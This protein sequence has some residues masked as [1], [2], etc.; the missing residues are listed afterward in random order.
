[1]RS[2]FASEGPIGVMAAMPEEVAAIDRALTD[3]RVE[4][5]G[6]RDYH[7]GRLFGR[8]VVAVTARI[9]K[10]AAASTATHLICEFGVGAI[11]LVGVAGGV[12]PGVHV[13]DVVVGAE[14]MQHDL[15]AS[16]LFPRFEAP[17]L[18]VA[19]FA[20]APEDI[21][22][23]EK[24]AG[25]FLA[26]DL[27]VALGADRLGALGVGAPRV[28]TG[29]I[30]TG[31]RFIASTPDADAVRAAAPEALA[32]EMEGAAVAQVCHEHGAGCLVI[33]AISDRA[34]EHATAAFTRALPEIAPV[35]AEGILRRLFRSVGAGGA[36]A[37]GD[38]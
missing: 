16:P 5:R 28:H 3:R 38:R 23:A 34:D 22:R 36:D 19:R 18:G 29:L 17:L 35:Y 24:A 11:V 37:G 6:L 2:V 20:S 32:V 12:G 30:A 14:T 33:R 8:D 26:S 9:G 10:V 1:M 13:G 27:P 4:V 7:T 21:E 31:D 25:A 15:D